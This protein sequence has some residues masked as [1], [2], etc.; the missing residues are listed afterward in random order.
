MTRTLTCVI[1]AAG[2]LATSMLVSSP[3]HAD[4]R[5]CRG[6]I[7]ATTVD[8]LRVPQGAVCKLNGTTVKGTITV[9]A[10]ATLRAE[11]VRVVGNVQSENARRVVVR[12]SSVGGSIQHVQGGSAE[13]RNNRVEGDV[14][15][16]RNDARIAITGNGSTATCSASQTP[17]PPLVEPTGSVATRKI[18]AAGSDSRLRTAT[19][20]HL[21]GWR[22]ARVIRLRGPSRIGVAEEGPVAAA[23][24]HP[25]IPQ[26]RGRA[27]AEVRG[28][29]KANRR[30]SGTSPRSDL[31]DGVSA[32]CRDKV[33]HNS[34]SA[35]RLSKP[36]DKGP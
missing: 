33:G 7:G 18:S 30:S 29:A 11:R 23:A 22:G 2:A 13:I 12:G 5:T 16:F 35:E 20:P 1:V 17:R 19:N 8:N 36:L 26:V 21:G 25:I 34:L 31:K 14:Q 32:P 9:Q 24:G 6:T 28:S 15:M 10:R 3:A 4:E 27:A